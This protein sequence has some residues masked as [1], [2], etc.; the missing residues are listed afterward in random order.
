MACHKVA[1]DIW[2][3]AIDR[4]LHLSA[5]HLPGSEN[6]LAD[7]ASRVFDLNTEWELTNDNFCKILALFCRRR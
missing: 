6:V 3:W 7:K 4:N 2:C 5:V 1:K